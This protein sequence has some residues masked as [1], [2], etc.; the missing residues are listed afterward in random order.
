[1]RRY[2]Y[3]IKN[4]CISEKSSHHKVGWYSLALNVKKKDTVSW[5]F[6]KCGITI[7]LHASQ[8]ADLNIKVL[9]DYEMPSAKKAYDFQLQ[10][11]SLTCE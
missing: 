7:A 2:V 3:Q 9:E 5:S 11:K 4:Y 10:S 8:N 1:M 6:Q